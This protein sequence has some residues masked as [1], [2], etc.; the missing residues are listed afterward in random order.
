[1]EAPRTL[2]HTP[3]LMISFE[4]GLETG[5]TKHVYAHTGPTDLSAVRAMAMHSPRHVRPCSYQVTI[6][7]W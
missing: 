5:L 1:M 2:A 7:W 3:Q 4:E 6:C